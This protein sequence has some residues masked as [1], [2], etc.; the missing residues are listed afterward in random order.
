MGPHQLDDI[1]KELLALLQ[2][3]A[4]C[5]ATELAE[6]IGVSDN[7]VHNR[8]RR[9]EEAGVLAGYRAVCGYD[10]IGLTLNYL[11]VATA[12]IVDRAA[13]AAQALEIPQVVEVTE[14]MTGHGNLHI[15]AIGIGDEDITK[16]AERLD[17]LRLEIVD[18]HLIRD[19]HDRP[20]DY[21]QLESLLEE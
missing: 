7:T 18:E 9:L 1:D 17:E 2:E 20:L 4:R 19:E 10:E 14:L 6:R 3:N 11:I 5:P 15:K 16:V 21:G 12:R 8:M 13:V